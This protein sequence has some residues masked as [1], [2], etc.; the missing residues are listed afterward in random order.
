MAR[1]AGRQHEAGMATTGRRLAVRSML[2]RPADARGVLG[3]CAIK[4]QRHSMAPATRAVTEQWRAAR[5]RAL[6]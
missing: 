3:H 2:E 5:G 4:P 6:H 1:V